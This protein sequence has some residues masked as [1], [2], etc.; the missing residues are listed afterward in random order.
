MTRVY[1]N[2]WFSVAYHY[3][4][5]IR[6]N[7]DGEAFTFYGTHPNLQHMSLLAAD[8]AETEPALEGRAYAEWCADFCRR[9]EIDV[10]IPRLHM[11]D[12][13]RYAG[14]FDAVGTRVMVCRDTELLD[15]MMEKDKFYERI[16]GLNL[17][18]IPEYRV[19]NTADGFKAA[20]EELTAKGLRVVFKPTKAEGGMGFRIIDNG[21]DPLEELYGYVTLSTTFDR[22]YETLSRVERFDDLMVM[23]LLEGTEYSIDCLAA[24]DGELITAIPRGKASG[25]LYR[26]EAVPELL[27]ISR[28]IAE[29]LRIPYAFNIQVKYTGDVPKL[30]EINPRMSGGLYITC[31]SGVNMPYLAIRSLL[32]KPVETPAPQFG[33]TAS[34]VEQPLLMERG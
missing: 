21:I 17:V 15:A 16:R 32:G 18:D 11:E 3:I 19:V 22:A 26:L 12:I 24:A 20:Y 30:L 28:R 7:P 33:I 31:L 1:L 8:H 29:T 4:R 2:R 6:D 10:F 25:R 14:L 34:Y 9:H 23:E 5:M 13:A 27:D